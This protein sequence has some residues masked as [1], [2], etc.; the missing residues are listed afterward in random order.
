MAT[1][2]EPAAVPAPA[3]VRRQRLAD[4]VRTD[5]FTR[6]ADAAA[7]LGVS[8]VTVRSDLAVLA[9]DGQLSRVHGG[10]MPRG[11]RVEPTVETASARDPAAKLAIGRA[12]AAL[13]RSGQSVVLDVGSTTLAVAHALVDRVDLDD[14]LV[15]TNGLSIALAL[16]PAVP[17]LTVVVTGG[18]LRSLQHSLVDPFAAS[19]LDE[20]ACD[21][22]ILGCNGVDAGGGVTGLNLPETD[23]KRRMARAAR[24]VVVVAEAGKLGRVS[25]ARIAP[26]AEVHVLVTDAAPERTAALAASGLEVVHARS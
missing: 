21:L 17:R 13:V 8:E 19:V 18:T 22:A 23:V 15:V 11:S 12:A 6:V 16:E 7:L 24:R 4:L 3:A 5:G 20:I 1:L 26:L 9:R 14:V 25:L 2:P 10:A